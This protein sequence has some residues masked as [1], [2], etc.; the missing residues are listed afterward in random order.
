MFDT[1]K[2][3]Y[4]EFI[5]FPG[6]FFLIICILFVW[7]NTNN[8][9]H[10]ANFLITLIVLFHQTC[11]LFKLL[12]ALI[13]SIVFRLCSDC[14]HCVD[15]VFNM[16]RLAGAA[17]STGMYS[18]TLDL[19]RRRSIIVLPRRQRSVNSAST[20]HLFA[21]SWSVLIVLIVW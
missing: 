2:R 15:F 13:M 6:P 11:R 20:Q 16:P 3:I 12:L 14:V 21:T 17:K 8:C 7:L 18:G 10:R 19:R 1:Q 9:A 4:I 5:I